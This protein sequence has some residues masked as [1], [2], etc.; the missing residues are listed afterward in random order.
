MKEFHEKKINE[1]KR[2]KIIIEVLGTGIIYD[3]GDFSIDGISYKDLREWAIAVINEIINV[4]PFT[5]ESEKIVD[6]SKAGKKLYWHDETEGL[7]AIAN[8]LIDRFEIK[9]EELK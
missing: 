9:P 7:P 3:K 4:K 1:L 8:F 2:G 6:R 5:E